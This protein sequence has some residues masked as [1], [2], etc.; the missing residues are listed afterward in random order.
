MIWI[1][2]SGWQYD[3]WKDRLYPD[4]LP[5]AKWLEYFSARFPTVEVNNSFYRLPSEASFVRW[6]QES[7]PDFQVTVKA[8]R[9]ITHIK[10]LMEPEDS[11]K[12]LWSRMSGLGPKL[13]TVLFQLPPTFKADVD[14]LKHFLAALPK[15]TPCAL[16]VRHPSWD[17]PEVYSALDEAGVAYVLGD[18][19]GLHAPDVVTGGW[20]Y[21]RFHQGTPEG[22][23]YP[24]DAMQRWADRIASMPASD[25]WVY[26]NNDPLGAALVDARTLTELL[27]QRLPGQ[28]RGP[29]EES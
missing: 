22:P 2:T 21:V 23:F 12:L 13:A 6:R 1:G 3:S 24:L 29:A 4:K 16:E 7:H 20:S 15:Q 18:R 14:R 8:S 19:P 11:I 9:Y 25:V 26:F 10:R 5:K 17:L 28:V 27:E